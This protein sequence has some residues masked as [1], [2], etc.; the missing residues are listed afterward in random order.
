RGIPDYL[1]H[2]IFE[3]FF[4]QGKANGTGLGLTVAQKIVEDHSGDLLLE[5]SSAKGTTFLVML[6]LGPRKP[7]VSFGTSNTA[8]VTP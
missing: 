4:T 5:S 7:S 8:A 6:P 2:R 3:P 1:Q